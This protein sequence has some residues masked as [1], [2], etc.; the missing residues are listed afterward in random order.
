MSY[1]TKEQLIEIARDM[2][3]KIN[4]GGGGVEPRRYK[5]VEA[6]TDRWLRF[7]PDNKRGLVIK[8]GTLIRKSNGVYQTYEEDTRVDLTGNLGT[9]G[10][11][12]FVNLADDGTITASLT[13]VNTGV[14][15]GRFHTLCADAGTLTMTA[16]ETP[17]SGLVVGGNFL[18]KAY[19][20]TY[21]PDFYAFYN[22]RITA[23]TV[24]A[25]YDVI[26]CVHPLSGFSAGDIL[27]ESV[28][29]LT[30]HPDTLYEDAMV[31]DKDTGLVVDVYLQSGTGHNTRSKYNAVHT[32]SREQGNHATD[33]RTVGKR[34]LR[35]N[36]FTSAALGSNEKTNIVGSADKTYVGGH[37]DTSNRR[38]VSAIGCEEMCGYLWQWCED[39]VTASQTNAWNTLDGHGSFGQEYWTPYVLIAG[40]HW[41]GGADC[42]SRSR[43]SKNLRSN[44]AGS[45]GGR[46]SSRVVSYTGA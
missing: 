28:F 5:A 19:S 11:D 3:N 40:G 39:L 4:A 43:G 24:Q 14:T 9:V 22:K 13:K 12:Y 29:C 18:V 33:M 21:D 25:K 34:L 7:D 46:G 36:E 15:I 10:G 37:V 41:S 38:M 32:V 16:P 20:E 6:A 31:Y 17:S 35:D 23:V 45:I 1:A 42:G 8:A 26:T 2:A 30:W 27:P 44:V